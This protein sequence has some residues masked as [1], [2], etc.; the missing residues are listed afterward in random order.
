[1]KESVEFWGWSCPEL[2][3]SVEF[4]GWRQEYNSKRTVESSVYIISFDTKNITKTTNIPL[5][6]IMNISFFLHKGISSLVRVSGN[7]SFS[8]SKII[9]SLIRVSKNILAQI[10]RR[11][12]PE[13]TGYC[14]LVELDGYC[15]RDDT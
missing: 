1:M 10:K 12:E 14:I 9:S 13:A 8:V 7:V 2:F 11:P 15:Q 3:G 4:W 6:I 5:S